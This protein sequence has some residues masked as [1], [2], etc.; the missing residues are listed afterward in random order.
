MERNNIIVAPQANDFSRLESE[1]KNSEFFDISISFYRFIT[2][3]GVM[4][5]LFLET[6]KMETSFLDN[7]M[8]R[9]AKV[10]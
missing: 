2:T 7:M 4:R 8:I 6:V 5:S 9:T 3:P 10:I 1:W